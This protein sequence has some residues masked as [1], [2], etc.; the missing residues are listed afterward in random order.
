M[1]KSDTEIEINGELYVKKGSEGSEG[2]KNS[3]IKIIVLQRGWVMIGRYSQKE[4]ACSLDDAS[5]IRTWGTTKGLGE[6]AFG[7][8]TS[9]TKLD[10]T[11]HVD[12]HIL[13]IV[14]SINCVESKWEKEL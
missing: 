2:P 8:P 10:K 6:L 7:G 5:V 3:N 9:T 4:D 14:A 1:A 12:F 13:T 11:G